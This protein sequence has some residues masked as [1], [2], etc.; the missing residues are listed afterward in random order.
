MV[1]CVNG[2]VGCVNGPVLVGLV[3]FP[4]G[5]VV[6]KSVVGIV[7]IGSSVMVGSSELVVVMTPPSGRVM[8][9]VSPGGGRVMVAMPPSGMVT[10]VITPPPGRV[11][12]KSPPPVAVS[13]VPGTVEAESVSVVPGTVE[14]VSVEAVSV[15]AG[16]VEGVEDMALLVACVVHVPCARTL[17]LI[18]VT[19]PVNAYSPPSTLTPDCR[20]I[21]A[22][23]RMFPKKL[24]PVPSVAE[25][26]TCQYTLQARAPLASTTRED[27]AVVRLEPIWNT[28][29]A[30]GLFSAFNVTVPVICMAEPDV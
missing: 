10:V 18:S 1:G 24:D 28:K 25:E 21:L 7:V 16:V 20:E 12:G 15:V 14:A 9:V 6:G 4:V 29:S 3:K 17:S 30:F 13:V 19:A 11:I 8:V 26:P 27:D 23:E 22:W 5:N 2:P